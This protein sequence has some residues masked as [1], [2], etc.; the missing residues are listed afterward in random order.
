MNENSP[1]R[2]S[3]HNRNDIEEG[4]RNR[5]RRRDPLQGQAIISVPRSWYT[6]SFAIFSVLSVSILLVGM[7]DY[8]HVETVS[9]EV[10]LDIGVA[11]LRPTRIGVV[12]E[13]LV[14]DG[15][16]VRAGQPLLRV[17]AAEYVSDATTAPDR[18]QT[19]LDSRGRHLQDQNAAIIAAA[20]A[21][22]SVLQSQIDGANKELST[23]KSQMA[24]QRELVRVAK[25]NLDRLQ[26]L[27]KQGFVSN[28]NMETGEALYFSRRQQSSQID[29]NIIAKQA[30]I[31]ANTRAIAQS[32]ANTNAQVAATNSYRSE[33]DRQSA[34]VDSEQGYTLVAPFDGKIT[35][36]T[37]RVGQP[38]ADHS[39]MMVIP[40]GARTCAE[41]YVP[42]SA[43][44]FLKIGQN[45]RLAIDAFPFAD[46]GT[47][48]AQIE[49]ISSATITRAMPT[50]QTTAVYLVKA[51]IAKPWIA[52]FGR[53]QP[54][55]PG[56]HLTARIVTRNQ[57]LI[58]WLFEP[59]YAV[60]NR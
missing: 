45:A 47:I 3:W 24:S 34:L 14:K 56:M 31:T 59:L 25:A 9:G 46:F 55:I 26:L 30:L 58:Q 22:Q 19:A 17:R 50:G 36:L 41:L 21:E 53:R 1:R 10:T 49:D 29:Q 37:A 48:D 27:A 5:T 11:E 15:S 18:M 35:G 43:I 39:L 12:S 13:I 60:I 16:S 28:R 42:T 8:P 32:Q 57:N 40:N 23:L 20:S 4:Q 44:G 6:I 54:L 7:A 2:L 38:T 33:I 52:A 51:S